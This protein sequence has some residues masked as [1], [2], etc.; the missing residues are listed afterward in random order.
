MQRR[1]ITGHG[2]PLRVLFINDTARNG[3]PGGTLLDILKFLDPTEIHRSVLLPRADIVSQRLQAAGAADA[4]RIDPCFIENLLQPFA[5]PIE[6]RDFTAPPAL[7]AV[8]SAGNIIRGLAGL[9]GLARRIRADRTELLFCNGTAANLVGGL[10][11][12]VTGVPALWHVFY[13]DVSALARPL[14]RRMAASSAVRGIICVS[15]PTAVQF[16]HCGEKV[17]VI[18]DALDIGEFDAGCVTPMLRQELGFASDTIIFGSHGRILPRKG[19][20]ALI[21]AARIVF[22]RLDAPVRARCRFV[23]LGDTPQDIRPD[24]LAEC[25]AM[26][27]EMGMEADVR[28]VGFRQEVRPYVADFDIALVPSVY[29]DPLPRAVLESMA[30]AKPVIAFDVGGIGEMIDDG[31][32]GRLVPGRP[33][34]IA[35]LAEAC[36][37]VV[38]NPEA[39]RARGLAARRRIERDFDARTHARTL[40]DA[41]L[42][43]AG[44]LAAVSAGEIQVE[45]PGDA[46][47]AGDA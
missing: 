4:I 15:A 37:D 27:Q 41:I 12:A 13:P 42:H 40:Q 7:R 3:G 24:H 1:A 20:V 31:V 2:E 11:A 43:A 39:W 17:R 25:R 38:A 33:P 32:E 8:R 45:N 21:R 19:F 28:F 18:H 23:V 47:A 14:H 16:G 35:A 5:R 46:H 9:T 44:R 30:L 29:E 22:D 10:V 34:D 26:V 36:L 6:R